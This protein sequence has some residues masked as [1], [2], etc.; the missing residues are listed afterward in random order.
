VVDGLLF[1]EELFEVRCDI[2]I[3][4]LFIGSGLF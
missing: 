4:G 1:V 2:L 3:M